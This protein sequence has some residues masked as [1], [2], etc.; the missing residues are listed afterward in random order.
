MQEESRIQY[1]AKTLLFS[2]V[3]N[4][5]EAAAL[6]GAVE[7]IACCTEAKEYFVENYGSFGNEGL[8]RLVNSSS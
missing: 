2:G 6:M 5:Q 4:V 3:L 1:L 7:T 8:L